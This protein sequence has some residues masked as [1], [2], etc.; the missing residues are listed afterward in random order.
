MKSGL[1]AK[2]L[3]LQVDMLSMKGIFDAHL[4]WLL[5]ESWFQN[6]QLYSILS[7]KIKFWCSHFRGSKIG[8][9]GLKKVLIYLFL[10]L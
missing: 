7:E 2:P 4:L 10:P 8:I 6:S 1:D 9:L 3:F 5:T